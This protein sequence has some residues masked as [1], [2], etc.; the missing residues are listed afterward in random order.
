MG[1]RTKRKW[2]QLLDNLRKAYDRD[3]E[4]RQNGLTPITDVFNRVTPSPGQAASIRAGRRSATPS[5]TRRTKKTIQ[6][7]LTWHGHPITITKDTARKKRKDETKRIAQ[8]QNYISSNDRTQ[9]QRAKQPTTIITP[10]KL[11]KSSAPSFGDAPR[12]P[13]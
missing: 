5:T 2:V 9:G 11:P 13:E 3:A 12:P 10:E 1:R 4:L 6:S 7:R 8:R